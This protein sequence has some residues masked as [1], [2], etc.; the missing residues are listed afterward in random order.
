MPP[1]WNLHYEDWIIGDG[2]PDRH[3][4]EVFDWFAVAFWTKERLTK[5]QGRSRSVVPATD[6]GYRVVA[7]VTYLSDGACIIDLV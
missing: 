3:V 6:H 4:D 1:E 5:I 7:E 2:Q